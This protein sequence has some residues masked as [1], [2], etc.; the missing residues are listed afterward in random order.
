VNRGI[1]FNSEKKSPEKNE[2]YCLSNAPEIK[3][4]FYGNSDGYSDANYITKVQSDNVFIVELPSDAA[5][6]PASIEVLIPI[7]T[8][9]NLNLAS[10]V[11]PTLVG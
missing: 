6:P 5:D 9:I 7:Q 1:P 10:T 2:I 8:K 11:N 3:C 4:Y